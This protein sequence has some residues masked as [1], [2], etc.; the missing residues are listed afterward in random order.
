[1]LKEEYEIDPNSSFNQLKKLQKTLKEDNAYKDT[2]LRNK[3]FILKKIEAQCMDYYSKKIQIQE[4]YDKEQIKLKGQN[5]PGEEIQYTLLENAQAE[6][7]QCCDPLTKLLFSFRNNNQILMDFIRVTEPSFHDDLANFLCHFFYEDIFNPNNEGGAFLMLVYL[8]LDEEVDKIKDISSGNFLDSSV[9][10]V[11]KLLKSLSRREDVRKYLSSI[12]TEVIVDLEGLNLSKS[13]LSEDSSAPKK[14]DFISMDPNKI[15]QYVKDNLK[16]KC[17]NKVSDYKKF[18]N[19]GLSVC[20]VFNLLNKNTRKNQLKEKSSMF[21]EDEIVNPIEIF[22]FGKTFENM[23]EEELEDKYQ[24]LDEFVNNYIES[25]SSTKKK[26]SDISVNSAHEYPE[27]NKKFLEER[28]QIEKSENLKE[29]FIRQLSK[30]ENDKDIYTNNKLLSE[31]TSK[32]EA[33]KMILVYQYSVETMQRYIDKLFYG[34]M[35]NKDSTPNILKYICLIIDRLLD[36][37]FPK[38]SVL[39]KNIFLSDFIF[40]TLIFPLLTNPSSNCLFYSSKLDKG[41]LINLT[42]ILKKF[43]KGYFFNASSSM[44]NECYFTALNS[45]FMELM[46]CLLNL[47]DS[48]RN[49]AL[50]NFIERLLQKKKS[51][52]PLKEEDIEFNYLKEYPKEDFEFQCVCINWKDIWSIY[53]TIKQKESQLIQNQS[54]MF[55][56]TYNKI[57]YHEKT[58]KKKI[59]DDE[60]NNKKSFIFLSQNKYVDSLKSKLFPKKETTSFESGGDNMKASENEKYILN[61]VKYS[62]GIIISHLNP[63]TR[64][65]FFIDDNSESTENFVKGLN[66]MIEL[67]GFSE[68]LKDQ[69]IPLSWFGLYLESNIEGIP[70]AHK[71]NNY[72]YLYQELVNES[73]NQLKANKQQDVIYHM[74]KKV[75]IAENFSKMLDCSIKYMKKVKLNFDVLKVIHNAVIPV[76]IKVMNNDD[77]MF[78]GIVIEDVNKIPVTKSK[79]FS[80][81]QPTKKKHLEKKC[82]TIQEF[83]D[84]FPNISET[85]VIANETI[86][87]IPFALENYFSMMYD[88][89]KNEEYLR[90]Y[91]KEDLPEIKII[92]ENYIYRGIY[93]KIFS[94]MANKKDI[95]LFK[96]CFLHSWIKI[97]NFH[98]KF[99]GY[100][101]NI[102]DLAIH[103][104]KLMDSANSPFDKLKCFVKTNEIL[105]N[106]LLLNEGSISEELLS[107]L[108]LYVIMNATLNR[109]SSNVFYIEM[110]MSVEQKS[111]NFLKLLERLKNAIKTIEHLSYDNFVGITLAQYK[112][113]ISQIQTG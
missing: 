22:L 102:L 52:V 29:Y 6:L 49:I 62:I 106:Y 7:S 10:F 1:M 2:F 38:I 57:S 94:E 48:M 66:K 59:A 83:V 99:K 81:S 28:I 53:D 63:L 104:L 110:F 47:Y 82:T 14:S 46:P 34:F 26:I 58:L 80:K 40:G 65:N 108:H 11:S 109:L 87:N 9:S 12:L 79:P 67:E 91:E 15:R 24:S 33:E 111:D 21:Y 45:Y 107:K 86:S 3:E 8:L 25:S 113:K 85:E 71:R 54:S 93:R 18:L 97:E 75:K 50:P 103:S 90:N 60:R 30:M 27:I 17:K 37:K 13:N 77:D 74:L 41:N 73:E 51:K 4:M 72:S 92:I 36:I 5:Q 64:A 70:Y 68:I 23:E 35:I 84:Y 78:E 69:T 98:S 55:Y 100:D 76:N 32:G 88:S 44:G 56:K 19:E 89:I 95:E 101:K 42:K 20:N 43:L 16:A 31:L 112:E 105:K 61:R 96:T 39:E